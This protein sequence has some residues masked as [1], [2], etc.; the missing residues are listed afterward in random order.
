MKMN[1]SYFT[2]KL[3]NLQDTNNCAKK[4]ETVD[5]INCIT[6]ELIIN[7]EKIICSLCNSNKVYKHGSKQKLGAFF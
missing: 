4:I 5:S 7:P 2:T 1:R 6:T 3:L